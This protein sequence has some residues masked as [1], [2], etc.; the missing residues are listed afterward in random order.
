MG[1]GIEILE[2]EADLISGTFDVIFANINRNILL[3]Q[4]GDYA[5]HLPGALFSGF[6]SGRT[7]PCSHS[8]TRV[9]AEVQTEK[10]GW[11]TLAFRRPA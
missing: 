11:S 1:K 10:E 2:G 7:T 3:A 9:A 6:Y 8:T 5:R 4:M